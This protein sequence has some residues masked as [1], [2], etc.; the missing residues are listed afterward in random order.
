M[1]CPPLTRCRPHAADLLRGLPRPP[2]QAA[3]DVAVRAAARLRRDDTSAQFARFVV[4]GAAST[5]LYALL[6][7]AS[8]GLGYLPANVIATV[9]SSVLANELHRRLTFHAEQRVSWLSA[10]VEAGGVSLLGLAATSAALGWLDATVGS[11]PVLQIALV[12]TVAAAI[13]LM[14][15]VAL[16]W[17]FRPAVPRPA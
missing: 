15:F 5:A 14:R 16:R 3:R 17:I 7:L 2:V 6:F 1:S 11:T 9:G 4:V 10:Q 8:W 12:A 13:G